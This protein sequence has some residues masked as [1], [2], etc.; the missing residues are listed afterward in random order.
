MA[1]CAHCTDKRQTTQPPL[2]RNNATIAT[3]SSAQARNL[4]PFAKGDGRASEAGRK[5]AE[6][7]RA[8]AQARHVD[9]VTM[10]N[11]L[12]TLAT[13]IE[14]DELGTLTL[15]VAVY[16]LGR[17]ATGQVP[18]RHASDAAELVR[19]LV[20]IA[21]LEAGQPTSTSLVAHLTSADA[22]ARLAELRQLAGEVLN[23]SPV[24]SA[25][26]TAAVDDPGADAEGDAEEGSG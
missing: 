20:D 10:V 26:A 1:T 14:R 12:R 11:T 3:M 22:R 4:T 6:T 19:V 24:L 15:G 13:A 21:R 16:V 7:R 2:A 18:I 25:A 17:V 8:K 9:N 23:P 5:G